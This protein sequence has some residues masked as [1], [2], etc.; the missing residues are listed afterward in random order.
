MRQVKIESSSGVA[1]LSYTI[2]TPK[3]NDAET[4]D[5]SLPTIILL[6]PVYVSQHIFHY[7]FASPDLRRFN[8]IAVDMRSHG[9]TIC[10]TPSTYR[11]AQA[12][13]DVFCFM[14]ALDLPPCHLF[15][16]SLGAC[17]ALEMAVTRPERALSLFLLSPLSLTEPDF[18]AAGRQ[19]IYDCWTA[20]Y[21]NPNNVDED[22]AVEA[23]LGAVQLGFGESSRSSFCNSIVQH[24]LMCSPHLW[25][26]AQFDEMHT[27]S[28]KFFL[29]RHPYPVSSLRKITCPVHLV[30]CSEDVAYSLEMTEEMCAHMKTAG[31]DVRLSQIANAPQIG[32]ATHPEPCVVDYLLYCPRPEFWSFCSGSTSFS[33]NGWCPLLATTPQYRPLRRPLRR[34]SKP[35]SSSAGS[36]KRSRTRKTTTY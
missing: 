25:S 19:E 20:A 9:N 4:I 21:K 33:S 8:L 7:Q 26:R 5:P 12:A 14:D 15:G 32:C 3:A 11:A 29:D 18:V 36:H 23:V 13:D 10:T 35:S 30:H 22:A 27:V 31:I 16:V 6:H 17:I 34:L 2:S 24:A 28:V 1:L